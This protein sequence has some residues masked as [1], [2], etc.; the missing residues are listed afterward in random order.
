MKKILENPVRILVLV[1]TLAL[2]GIYCAFQLPMSLFP[3]SSRPKVYMSV[4]YGGY[5]AEE[6]IKKYGSN[7]EYQLQAIKNT[8]L[9]IEKVEGTYS[10]NIANYI[11]SYDWNVPFGQALKEVQTVAAGFKGVLP[12]ESADSINIYQWNENA[13]FLAVSFFS[14]RYGPNE[15]YDILDPILGPELKKNPDAENV[16][17][18]NPESQEMTV[19]LIPEKLA[20]Y[21]LMPREV[22]RVIENSLPSLTGSNVK[23]G[24][25]TANFQIPTHLS[26]LSE[27][28]SLP[29]NLKGGKRILLKDLAIIELGKSEHQAR[30]FKTN[31]KDSLI[32][33][34]DPK[35]G[36]NVKRMAENV[37]E[38][39]EQKKDS[40]PPGIEYRVLVDPSGFIRASIKSLM[41]DVALAA[42]LA[43]SVLFLFIGSFKNVGTAALEIPL[44]M[45]IAFIV[46]YYSGMNLNLISLGGLALAAGMN[47]D[48]SVVVLE[49]IFKHQERWAALNRGALSFSQRLM[50]IHGAVKEVALPVFLST[51]T[52]LIVFIPL[53][54]T[55]DLTNAILGDLAKAVIYSHAVSAFVAIFVVPTIRLKLLSKNLSVPVAPLDKQL[56]WLEKKYSTFLLKFLGSPKVK[57]VAIALPIILCVGL[58]WLLIPKLPKEVVGKPDTDWIYLGTTSPKAQNARHFE[59]I[60]QEVESKALN[61]L[62][63]KVA[64]TFVQSRGKTN[65]TVMLR[66]KNKKDMDEVVKILQRE[67]PNSPDAY[68]YAGAW[69]PAE[70]P[71]PEMSHYE[72]QITGKNTK[73][74]QDTASRV[75]FFMKNLGDYDR[76]KNSPGRFYQFS[77]SFTPYEEIWTGLAAANHPLS[78]SD[79]TDLTFYSNEGKIP[80]SMMVD[81][82]LTPVKLM[83]NDERL[84]DPEV[85]SA[86]PLKIGDKVIPLSA[87]GKMEL[88]R[89]AGEIFRKDGRENVIISATLDKEK[90]TTWEPLAKK[91][92][93]LIEQNKDKLVGTSGTNIEILPPQ[94]EL[95][96]A[97]DQL[98]TS[99][100]ISLALIFLVLWMQ[101]QSV[102][103][104]MIIMMTIP[105]GI[106]GVVSSLYIFDSTLSLNSALGLI[107]LNGMTVNN[108]I[109]LMDVYNNER[110]KDVT[111]HEAILEACRSRLRPI[112]ITSLTTILGMAPI[113]LGWGDGGKIL[114]PLGI[115]VTF[116]MMFSTTT[117]LIIVPLIMSKKE[118]E[119]IHKIV[120]NNFVEIDR[121]AETGVQPWQ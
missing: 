36:A 113:A 93:K 49:N 92:N 6:F 53:T 57:I 19:R 115:S 86:Y 91:Y 74:I 38:V 14:N 64:Y 68:Y 52:T 34:A 51:A 65:G 39:I 70:L 114:Q 16:N 99:L 59:N 4:S 23:M 46:M 45:M 117:A 47:V 58:C 121:I 89:S 25:E 69:N 31:G 75:N 108:S 95:L 77:Y 1:G 76:F 107:L 103:Q 63:G 79:V 119:D 71:L 96:S 84:Q 30:S 90:E 33:F 41:S 118:D 85:L 100:L 110:R 62:Q 66:L 101:F 3:Q 35:S 37:L 24:D 26:G 61:L 18:Y 98:K 32:L 82:K 116:G 97:L 60:L 87:L 88:Q 81:G 104:V 106:I 17:L 72:L 27:L 2:L 7:I 105:L 44:S 21:N 50:L 15:L 8:G 12:K 55:S 83:F 28:E 120:E 20:L 78:L 22:Y 56:R 54:M 94:K 11:I 43:V 42:I 48:A 112:L 109:L 80:G 29:L 111:Q 102:Q 67:F 10:A 13:G 5:S 73:S 9:D 40:F